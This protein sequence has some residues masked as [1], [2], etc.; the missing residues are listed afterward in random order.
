MILET[1]HKTVIKAAGK[2]KM[3]QPADNNLNNIKAIAFDL[4]G[5]VYI[6]NT[7]IPG[8]VM[9]VQ[10]LREKGFKI[11]FVTNN[12][13]KKREYLAAKLTS[14]GIKANVDDVFSSGYAAASLVMELSG[15]GD[16][17]HVIGSSDFKEEIVNLGIEITQGCS[18]GLLVVGI[19]SGFNY[20]ML[21]ASLEI[22]RGGATF[23]VCNR[24]R[25][26]PIEN[27]RYLPGCGPIV[28]AIE[29]AWG[30]VAHYDVGK[31]NTKLLE[32]ISLKYDL[33][34]SEILVVGD[35]IDSDI[36][37]AKRFGA[38][39]VLIPYD[40]QKKL[41]NNSSGKDVK[42]DFILQKIEELIGMLSFVPAIS[43]RQ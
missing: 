30:G 1:R 22:L 13:G 17:V 21:S 43:Q 27:G 12:S 28:A 9:T 38:K 8:A 32:M 23:I 39:S 18:C 26:F 33:K 40:Q 2:E 6:G 37:M 36:A 25:N 3:N 42:P 15:S 5:V 14:M 10:A 34:P 35:V 4:D 31:P 7:V 20:E 29:W 11:F 16:K 19:D 24:D 41:Q